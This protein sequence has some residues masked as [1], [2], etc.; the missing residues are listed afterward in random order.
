LNGPLNLTVKR[1][2]YV[3]NARVDDIDFT[4]RLDCCAKAPAD[5]YNPYI[6]GENVIFG[7]WGRHNFGGNKAGI[8]LV[9]RV[10]ARETVRNV[11]LIL[12]SDV[13]CNEG[14][15]NP[16]L[17]SSKLKFV[18][19]THESSMIDNKRIFLWPL[20]IQYV[21]GEHARNDSPFQNLDPAT[22]NLRSKRRFITNFLGQI[23]DSRRPMVK[24]IQAS[25]Q[26]NETDRHLLSFT[27][28]LDDKEANFRVL[29]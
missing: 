26:F 9:Q 20:G 1:Q 21:E 28:R 10:I 24:A 29:N 5:D 6:K 23:R 2:T 13:F 12:H 11:A 17:G 3:E 25:K 4:F 16:I 14:Y 8:R 7:L 19:V 15:L 27:Q 22:V 18:Y